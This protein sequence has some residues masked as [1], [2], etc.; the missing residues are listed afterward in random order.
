M[1]TRG[2]SS[3]S[4][5]SR[6]Q[7]RRRSCGTSV[8]AGTRE[9][10]G[11]W[12]R[13]ARLPAHGSRVPGSHVCLA[14]FRRPVK[15]ARG[16]QRAIDHQVRVLR[17]CPCSRIPASFS[18]LGLLFT[19]KRCH[20]GLPRT[21]SERAITACKCRPLGS[22]PDLPATTQKPAASPG[23]CPRAPPRPPRT[24]PPPP[25]AAASPGARRLDHG[26][27][28]L[29]TRQGQGGCGSSQGRRR[30]PRVSRRLAAVARRQLPPPAGSRRRV[31]PPP[32]VAR[33]CATPAPCQR[34]AA[35]CPVAS[36]ACRPNAVLS[37]QG[38]QEA[39]AG[40][41][42]GAGV[43]PRRPAGRGRYGP[44]APAVAAR[45]SPGG[46]C[47]G[48]QRW[49]AAPPPPEPR[50]RGARGSVGAS[51]AARG[52]LAC[53]WAAASR[54]LPRADRP[55]IAGYSRVKLA[56]HRETGEQWACK[57]RRWAGWP[58]PAGRRCRTAPGGRLLD[59][60][61]RAPRAAC[62]H[63]RPPQVTPLPQPGGAPCLPALQSRACLDVSC[64]LPRTRPP[65]ARARAAGHPAAQARQARERVPQRPLRDHE[66]GLVLSALYTCL[67]LRLSKARA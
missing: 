65:P 50:P 5:A 12:L 28:R 3:A 66:G 49:R 17:S 44:A 34:Q 16:G 11:G 20:S 39:A 24:P 8:S 45:R 21:P 64:C 48:Q 4:T 7:L 56:T 25:A 18:E 51:A 47:C 23:S 30:V 62:T 1:K 42:P 29:R 31:P 59:C 43:R 58:R 2:A 54:S 19:A 55:H 14:G 38:R 52:S 22:P 57:V 41:H 32:P 6:S 40:R 10:R 27:R 63:A 61:S 15:P 60:A 53:C 33:P 35:V 26:L 46:A 67:P 9:R 13:L 37:L 36:I